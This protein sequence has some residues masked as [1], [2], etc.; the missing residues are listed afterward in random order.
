MGLAGRRYGARGSAAGAPRRR[1]RERDSAGRE[2][3]VRGCT[4]GTERRGQSLLCGVRGSRASGARVDSSSP[5][6]GGAVAGCRIR[7]RAALRSGARRGGSAA[8]RVRGRP[9][10]LW[11]LLGGAALHSSGRGGVPAGRAVAG[12]S[13]QA[14]VGLFGLGA[15]IGGCHLF[16]VCVRQ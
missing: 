6:R 8:R 1:G 13:F 12:F 10:H 16:G 11:A 14:D 9:A 4:V 7:R 5:S 3:G 2:V 15:C